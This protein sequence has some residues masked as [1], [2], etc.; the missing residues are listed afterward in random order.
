MESDVSPSCSSSS[1]QESGESQ[2]EFMICSENVPGLTAEDLCLQVL[3]RKLKIEVLK[4]AD[5]WE[6]S[7]VYA[8]LNKTIP[9]PSRL[10]D[11]GS[12]RATS[13]EN[14]LKVVVP[15]CALRQPKLERL[16][17]CLTAVATLENA[18]CCG[19]PSNKGEEA[20]LE[21]RCC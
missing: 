10:A 9:L 12:I 19:N 7:W 20:L 11:L 21:S 1:S 15:R 16:H 18:K 14:Q 8:N 17:V 4:Q 6:N 3:G 5:S 2:E 13:V